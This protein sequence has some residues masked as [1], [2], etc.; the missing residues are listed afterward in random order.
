MSDVAIRCE[1]VGK[2]FHPGAA[3]P[4]HGLREKL[5]SLFHRRPANAA[6]EWVWGLRDV[7]FEVKAGSVFGVTGD[8]GCG[9]SVLMKILARVTK[10]SQG[11]AV[12]NG[13]IGSILNLGSMLVPEL[14]GR[15]NIYQVGTLLRLR[16]ELIT[17]RFDEIVAFSGI[18]PHLD[19]LVRGYSAGMQM[20]LAFAV[21]AHLDSDVLLIDEGLSVADQDFR[22]Q[23]MERIRQ[24]TLM[25]RTVVIVSHELDMM[26]VHCDQ[27]AVFDKG[28]LRALGEAQEVLK[29]YKGRRK[30]REEVA[31]GA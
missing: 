10:P 31:H 20:R 3:D 6:K 11:R 16:R 24:M 12:V 2:R 25:G 4:Y 17:S 8:N 21:F 19:S 13:S 30:V 27:I 22:T 5:N 18:E 28:H 7:S 9:K 1:G 14:T 26:A 23:C 29:D 15:E